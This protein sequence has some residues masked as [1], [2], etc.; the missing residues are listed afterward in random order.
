MTTFAYLRVSLENLH[1]DNQKA[2]IIEHGFAVDEWIAEEGVSGS[3]KALER[4]EFSRMV[5]K[6]KAGDRVVCTMVDRLGR[7]AS[8]VLNTVEELQR[9]G[10][11]VI[12]IQFGGVD[13]T[14]SMGKMVLTVMAACAELEKNL[15]IE[16]TILGMKRTKDAGT[17]LGPPLKITPDTLEDIVKERASGFSVDQI[18]IRRKLPVATV[19][20]NLKRWGKD[21]GGYRM[22]YQ[23]R[24]QQH[25]SKQQ[26]ALQQPDLHIS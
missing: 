13:V 4:P 7:S 24:S 25:F 1:S 15:L 5:A 22:E 14:S 11:H 17:K 6:A 16:R 9:R 18:S 20:Q 3:V 26:F 2:S 12:V 10:V 23:A 8:D 19:Y 21:L